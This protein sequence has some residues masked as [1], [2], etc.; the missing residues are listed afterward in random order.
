MPSKLTFCDPPETP[1]TWGFA[2]GAKFHPALRDAK[3]DLFAALSE[4]TSYYGFTVLMME[5]LYTSVIQTLYW[6][7]FRRGIRKQEH[8]DFEELLNL[9]FERAI[10]CLTDVFPPDSQNTRTLLTRLHNARKLR[11]RLVHRVYAAETIEYFSNVGG[12]AKRIDQLKALEKEVFGLA[13]VIESVA[14]AYASD[15]GITPEMQS[16]LETL[17]PGEQHRAMISFWSL[18]QEEFNRIIATL[19]EVKEA[20]QVAEDETD[21]P[22]SLDLNLEDYL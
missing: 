15:C 11:N 21:L 16:F 10:N 14:K 5:G 2:L 9:S 12:V 3:H 7:H 4:F 13:G 17:P 6:Y 22:E 18:P 1:I 19:R 20:K 8:R